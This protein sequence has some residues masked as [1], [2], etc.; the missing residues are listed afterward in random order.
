MRRA[1]LAADPVATE[2]AAHIGRPRDENFAWPRKFLMPRNA[3]EE[4]FLDDVR[5]LF[6]APDD[7]VRQA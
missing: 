4:G 3:R 5:G 7:A 2:V 1:A 6:L